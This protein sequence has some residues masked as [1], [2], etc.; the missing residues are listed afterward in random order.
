MLGAGNDKTKSTGRLKRDFFDWWKSPD[1]VTTNAPKLDSSV[2]EVMEPSSMNDKSTTTDAQF[3]ESE[4][5]E[6]A[7]TEEDD[8]EIYDGSGTQ[9]IIDEIPS[10]AYA[11]NR[12]CK[13]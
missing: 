1:K 11:S 7:P 12:F 13:F 4:D 8:N 5:D 2:P 6:Y 10:V 3:N 9:D